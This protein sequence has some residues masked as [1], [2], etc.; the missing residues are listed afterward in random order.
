MLR[1]LVF[2]DIQNKPKAIA[3]I[4]HHLESLS[5]KMPGCMQF[6]FGECIPGKMSHYFFMDF[7]NESARDNYV[8]HP[9]HIRIAEQ[10][11]IPQLKAGIKSAV[12]FDYSHLSS[13]KIS[14]MTR[15]LT[16]YILIK[17]EEIAGTLKELTHYCDQIDR[18][19]PLQNQS[20]EVLGKEYPFALKVN[21]KSGAEPIRLSQSVSFWAAPRSISIPAGQVSSA[22][23]KSRL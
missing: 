11:I 23:L 13:K 19:K 12:V 18:L 17:N 9:E 7:E 8:N 16:G 10:V 21:V 20:M 6:Y 1:H 3:S 14:S 4:H 5:Q 22:M 15:G 2:L